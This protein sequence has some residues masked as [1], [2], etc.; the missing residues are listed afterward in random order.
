LRHIK[1]VEIA[2]ARRSDYHHGALRA[3]LLDAAQA[4]L[5]EVGV[6]GFSLRECAKRAGVSHGAPAHHFGD[7][8]GLLTAFATVGFERMA[9][10]MHGYAE[11]AGDDADRRLA[12][13]GQAYI[14]FALENPAHF[15]LM[16]RCDRLNE[17]DDRLQQ[18]GA[19]AAQA[20]AWALS[21]ALERR[22]VG[23][24]TLPERCLLAWSGVHGLAMLLLDADLRAFG[25]HG[26]SVD[27]ARAPAARLIERLLG[28][29]LTM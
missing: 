8:M 5:L 18:A 6:D 3:A 7:V 21:A 28:A 27:D 14:D 19:A 23:A 26:R 20:L 16:F 10:R 12:A 17:S 22:G 13:V 9:Q 1:P 4:L 2:A 15:R 29:L 11:A 25:V 24:Q